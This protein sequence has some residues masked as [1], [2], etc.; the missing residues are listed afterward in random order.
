MERYWEEPDTVLEKF[1]TKI[2]RF[3]VFHGPFLPF[4]LLKLDLNK[5]STLILDAGCGKGTPMRMVKN[6]RRFRCVGIDLYLPYLVRCQKEKVYDDYVRC[7]VRKL[8]FRNKCFSSAILFDVIEHLSKEDGKKCIDELERVVRNQI[9]ITTPT[10]FMVQDAYD[11]NELQIH[12]SLWSKHDFEG[13]GY[14]VRGLEG[15]VYLRK[16]KGESIL[17][18]FWKFLALFLSYLSQFFIYFIP[19]LAY[20]IFCTKNCKNQK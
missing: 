3:L 10:R 11:G 5:S 7:D 15:L 19:R 16:E 8:P 13:V 2:M 17:G 14:V 4:L 9:A 18:G 12:R 20:S 1:F 6:R